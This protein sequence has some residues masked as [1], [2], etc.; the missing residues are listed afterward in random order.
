MQKGKLGVV[1]LILAI[2][3]TLLVSWTMSMDV[4]TVQVTKYNPLA[5][6]TGEFETEQT[7]DYTSYSPSTNYTGYYTDT[8]TI[9]GTRYFDGVEFTQSQSGNNFRVRAD[10][11]TLISGSVTLSDYSGQYPFTD[12]DLMVSLVYAASEASNGLN[13]SKFTTDPSVVTLSSYIQAMNVSGANL[14]KITSNAGLPST[15]NSGELLELDAVIFTPTGQWANISDRMTINLITPARLA[16]EGVQNGFVG[17]SGA[18]FVL[19]WLSCVVDVD[20][21]LATVYYDNDCSEDWM[22]GTFSL[23]DIVMMYGGSQSLA[24]RVNF[25]DTAD[26]EA[27]SYTLAYMDPSKG[28]ELS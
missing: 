25:A 14:I 15:Y 28:V 13:G 27:I 18:H 4:N 16:Q 23:S 1:I 17:P 7:P 19:P 2:T 11:Q 26:I 22:A 8:S 10:P 3:G 24:P 9:G 5:D 21:Q 6:I 20:S 12:E